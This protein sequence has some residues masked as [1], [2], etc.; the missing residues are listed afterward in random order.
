MLSL[1]QIK[2]LHFEPTTLC[3]AACPQCARF[4]DNGEINPELPQ[5]TFSLADLQKWV[6]ETFI[7]SLDKMYMCGTYGEPT[8]ARDCLEIYKW[9]KKVNPDIDLGLNTNGSARTPDWWAE[10]ATLFD[11]P[12]SYVVFSLDGLE[13]TNHIYRQKTSWKKIMANVAAFIEAGG[14]AHWDMIVFEHNEHQVEEARMLARTMGFKWFRVKVSHRHEFKKIQWLNPPR[15]AELMIVNDQPGLSCRLTNEQEIYMSAHGHV[16]PCC[17]IGEQVFGP[18]LLERR[19]EL[20]QV[21]GNLDEYHI[22][23]GLENILPLF[24]RT[25]DTWSTSSPL[26]ICVDTCSGL[27]KPRWTTQW[28]SDEELK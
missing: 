28:R 5:S 11:T 8:V 1:D 22:S 26:Q 9:F 19:Q 10:L 6:P 15:S 24:N 7:S 21:L 13:D 27:N 3:N 18:H 2:T 20:R 12:R 14:P 4:L 25:T 16:L 23:R 17:Y